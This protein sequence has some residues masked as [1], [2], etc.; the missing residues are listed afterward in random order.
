M[1]SSWNRIFEHLLNV[2]EGIILNGIASNGGNG[3]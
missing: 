1:V 2:N 3:L